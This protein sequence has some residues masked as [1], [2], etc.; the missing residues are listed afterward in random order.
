M[1]S[2]SNVHASQDGGELQNIIPCFAVHASR[3]ASFHYFFY[4]SM[5]YLE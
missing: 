2:P 4:N 5:G 3:D 1:A